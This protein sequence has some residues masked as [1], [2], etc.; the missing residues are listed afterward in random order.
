MQWLSRHNNPAQDA[1]RKKVLHSDII[2]I[3]TRIFCDYNIL[4]CVAL[5]VQT[6]LI[7]MIALNVICTF[8]YNAS[9][10]L[11]R[12]TRFYFEVHAK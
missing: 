7:E 2:N 4:S 10:L 12:T 3:Q 11:R 8:L 6:L 5:T 9:A 1:C